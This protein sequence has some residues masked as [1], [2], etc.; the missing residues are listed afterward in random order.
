MKTNRLRRARN[1]MCRSRMKTAMKKVLSSQDPGEAAGHLNRAFSLFD[2]YSRKGII[3][4][5]AA[6]R[7]KSRL[8]RHVNRLGA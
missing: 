3:P 2:N 8:M 5:N 7:M 6:A 1:R 4:K